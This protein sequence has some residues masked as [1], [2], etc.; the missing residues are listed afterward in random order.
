MS[1]IT[2]KSSKNGAR[3]PSKT[4]PKK[5]PQTNTAKIEKIPKMCDFGVPKKQGSNEEWTNFSSLFRL[6]ASLGPLWG[7]PGSQNGP[8]TSP[9]SL[10]D[11]SGRRFGTI[12]AQFWMPVFGSF[13]RFV[14]SFSWRT[15]TR[16]NKERSRHGGG[17]GPQ[18]NWI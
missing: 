14:D 2:P 3:R 4:A 9:K 10:K 7:T 5:Y 1:K 16:K 11:P 6:R 8:K 15:L 17:D 13:F 18:G 12:F